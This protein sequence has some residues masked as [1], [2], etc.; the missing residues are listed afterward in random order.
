L[1]GYD[2]EAPEDDLVEMI[3]GVARSEPEKSDV[4]LFLRKWMRK[5]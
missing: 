2:F 5:K 4:A 1:N 3:Y